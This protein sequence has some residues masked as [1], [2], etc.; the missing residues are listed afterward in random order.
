[1]RELRLKVEVD[2]SSDGI[3]ERLGRD[4]HDDLRV[5][6]TIEVVETGSLPRFELK[7]RRLQVLD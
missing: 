1:M 2:G 5:R 7:A 4:I 6:A 3:I